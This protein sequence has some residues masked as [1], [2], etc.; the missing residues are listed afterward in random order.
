MQKIVFSDVDGTL[1]NS[2]HQITPRTERAIRQ[3]AG[4]GVPFV[5]VSGR[6]P[7]GIYPILREYG[8]RCPIISYSGGLIMDESGKVLSHKGFPKSR[9][10][11]IIEFLETSRFDLSWCVYSLDQWIV[12][13]RRDPRIAREE[14]IVKAVAE[15]G[16][17]DSARDDQ[18]SKILCICGPGKIADVE[19]K[20]KEAFP[21]CAIVRSSDILLE[22]MARGTA[23]SAAV[24]TLCELWGVP[25]SEAVAFGDHYNDVDMLEAVGTG[26]LM[27]NAPEEL[28]ARIKR[29]TRDND[30]DGIYYGLLEMG[31]VKEGP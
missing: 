14:A 23:K 24:R 12:K 3:L 11:E 10:K 5:I 9:A 20:L 4:A 8:F 6:G 21:D 30:H 31:L 15:E 28:K 2:E 18:I 13:D 17:A 19:E 1:L 16:S 29:Q 22:V 7:S 27:G 26:F 25:L